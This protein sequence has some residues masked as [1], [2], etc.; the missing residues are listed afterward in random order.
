MYRYQHKSNYLKNCEFFAAFFFASFE[1]TRNFQCFER[2]MSLIDQV[3][4][5]LQ[6]PRD[7]LVEMHDRA[8]FWNPFAVNLLKRPK[9]LWDLQKRPFILLFRPFEPN[10]VN[11]IY[12]QLDLR[13]WDCLI[14][15]WLQNTSTHVL[16]Q[17]ISRYQHKSNYLKN[18]EFFATFFMHFWNVQ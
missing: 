2:K 8:S 3:F 12:F 15:R 17:R 1:S 7:V 13:F 10:R 9:N 5:K 14:K 6:T 11:K 4:L 18:L 16:I